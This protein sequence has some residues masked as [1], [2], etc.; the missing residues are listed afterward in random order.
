[1]FCT[2][3]NFYGDELLAPRPTTELEDNPL[4]AVH[5]Y[6]FNVF[7]ATYH[8]WR[9]F[10]HPQTEDAPCRGD[11]DPHITDCILLYNLYEIHAT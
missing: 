8:I 1:M 7:A 3:T 4:S 5:S 11:R 9:R 10:L 6:L 2:M